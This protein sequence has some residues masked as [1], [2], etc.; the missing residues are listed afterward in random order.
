MVTFGGTLADLRKQRRMTQADLA[1]RAGVSRNTISL[2]ERNKVSP[3]LVSLASL[4][5]ALDIPIEELVSIY[6]QAQAEEG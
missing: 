1:E 2:I 4:S 3:M 5:K 6:R